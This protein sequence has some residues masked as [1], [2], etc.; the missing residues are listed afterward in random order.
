MSYAPRFMPKAGLRAVVSTAISMVCVASLAACSVALEGSLGLGEGEAETDAAAS[1][2][3]STPAPPASSPA[4]PAD[5]APPPRDAAI[6]D[7]APKGSVATIGR[8]DARDPAGPRAGWPGSGL[9]FRF[10]GTKAGVSFRELPGRGGPSEWDVAV[11]GAWKTEKLV[12]SPGLSTYD[13]AADLANK[14]HVV[15][16][17]RRN[18]GLQG[19]TQLLGV[20]VPGG[21]LLPPPPRRARTFEFL[22]DSYT[23]GY[24]IE[25]PN[26]RCSYSASTQNFHRTF[27]ARVAEAF[28]ADAIAVAYQGKGLTKNYER[29]TAP[30]FP[31]LYGRALPDDATSV[32]DPRVVPVDA[33]FVMLG[34][35]DYLQEKASVFDPPSLTAFRAAYEALLTRVRTN[36]PLAHVFALVSPTQTDTS[37]A[38]YFARTNQVDAVS[39]AV[40]ARAAAG[41]TRVHFVSAPPE[42]QSELSACDYHPS[43]GVHERLANMLVPEVRRLAGF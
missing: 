32:W 19:T 17:V 7:A 22:G 3:P 16:L 12:L 33:V 6:P 40:A 36:A 23:N 43:V 41:D 20:T 28:G 37:P 38:S 4:S 14:E 29:G 21:A 15:E 9:R 26:A 25:G 42:P 10:V 18:E 27:A 11:D 34:A 1:A 5:A 24:G 8:W 39:G 13:V 30:L 35:N 31:E 2:A